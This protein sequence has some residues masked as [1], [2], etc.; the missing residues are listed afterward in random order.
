MITLQTVNHCWR[1]W[2][3][4]NLHLSALALHPPQR[5]RAVCTICHAPAADDPKTAAVLDYFADLQIE[6]VRWDFREMPAPELCRRAIGRNR[7]CLASRADF[8]LLGDVDYIFGPGALDACAEAMVAH[9]APAMF[10]PH[11]VLSSTTHV[12]G[13]AE[14]A[15]VGRPQIMPLD[16]EAYV[17]VKMPRPIGG[18]QWCPGD[19]ARKRGY[20]PNHS[21]F[22]SPANVWRRTFEDRIFRMQ[23]GLDRKAIDVPNVYRIRHGLRGRFDI[24]VEL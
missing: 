12:A 5:C 24:G 21:K 6:N 18:T 7:V 1:Y 23:S 2:R 10:Y 19:F 15:R 3:I 11:S 17:R 4:L 14:I 16:P 9:G 13:D 20:L 8:V 22:Q